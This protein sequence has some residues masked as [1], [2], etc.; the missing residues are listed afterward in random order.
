[1]PKGEA[2]A[3]VD[4]C[5]GGWLAVT[6]DPAGACQ[7]LEIQGRW[8]DL[9]LN[10]CRY[11]GVD[12]PIGLTER[13]PR[14]CDLEA[15]KLL[16]KGRKS[17]VFAPPRRYMLTA[18][19]WQE[20]HLAGRQRESCG[21]SRQSW[22]IGA[23]IREI[24][25]ALSPVDQDRIREVHPELVFHHLASGN[26]LP[27]KRSA[28]GQGARLALLEA[29]GIKGVQALL[30][31][32]SRAQAGPDD[33]LDAAACALTARRMAFGEARRLPANPDCDARGLRM[34]IWF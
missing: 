4:G 16:P 22:N 23:K 25:A 34:E 11:V 10:S 27:P 9:A 8:Q 29:A 31:R 3:G 19:S 15:R 14:A 32:L 24:D 33:L 20:A 21:L 26:P 7:G 28:A 2:F 5:R 12:M 18:K 30:G 17:S 6:L 1:M 13:G